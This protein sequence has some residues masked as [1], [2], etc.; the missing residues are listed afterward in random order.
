MSPSTRYGARTVSDSE[1]CKTVILLISLFV[2]SYLLYADYVSVPG[3][4][5]PRG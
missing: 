2:L 4:G 5:C 1:I 3:R